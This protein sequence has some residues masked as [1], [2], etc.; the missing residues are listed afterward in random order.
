M[1]YNEKGELIPWLAESWKMSE[2]GRQWTFNLRKGVKWHN[3]DPFTSA[4]VK[5][6]FERFISDA[7]KSSWSPMH[8]QTVDQIETPDDYTVRVLAKVA[9]V[10]V[11]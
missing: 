5:F 9:A 1:L 6:S 4:D 11:L 2:D 10:R 3:G 8:R 7:A